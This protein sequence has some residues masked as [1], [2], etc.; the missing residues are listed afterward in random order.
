MRDTNYGSQVSC[1][2]QI[3]KKFD[4]KQDFISSTSYMMDGYKK[5]YFFSGY[6]H[7]ID[8]TDILKANPNLQTYTWGV[9]DTDLAEFSIN[10]VK[11][12][13]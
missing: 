1:Y 3:L 4:Y 6:D 11:S 8:E 9:Y 13:I 5:N 10:R 7:I 2:P 12:S